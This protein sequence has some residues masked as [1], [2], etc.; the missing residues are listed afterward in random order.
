MNQELKQKLETLISR[1]FEKVA[2]LEDVMFPPDEPTG[3]PTL[4]DY[5]AG[6]FR[7]CARELSV[8]IEKDI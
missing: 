3:E 6:V 8:E 5:K 4:D 1:W 2:D 7:Q